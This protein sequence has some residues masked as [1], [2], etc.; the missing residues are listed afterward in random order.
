MGQE[1]GKFSLIS[2]RSLNIE[3][4]VSMPPAPLPIIV[5]SPECYDLKVTAFNVPFTQI[6]SSF[7]IAIGLT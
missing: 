7:D 2:M 3:L 1:T 5:C 4:A 6:G